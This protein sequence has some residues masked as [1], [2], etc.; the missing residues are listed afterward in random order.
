MNVFEK[1]IDCDLGLALLNGVLGKNNR[2]YRH[3]QKMF[4]SENR[5]CFLSIFMGLQCWNAAYS[6]VCVVRAT[7]HS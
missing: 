3:V 5:A 6:T 1:S 4:Q 7:Y 2:I